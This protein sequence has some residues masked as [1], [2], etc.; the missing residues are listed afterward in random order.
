M[1]NRRRRTG[2]V[3]RMPEGKAERVTMFRAMQRRARDLTLLLPVPLLVLALLAWGRSY[4]P[5]RFF[6]RSIDGRLLLMFGTTPYQSY[7]TLPDG[8]PVDARRVFGQIRG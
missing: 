8:S 3:Y 2:R 6:C 5:E 4:L 7:F 1:L